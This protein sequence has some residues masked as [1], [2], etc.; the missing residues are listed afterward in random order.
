[1][2]PPTVAAR[3]KP[4]IG[5]NETNKATAAGKIVRQNTSRRYARPIR[6]RDSTHANK[7]RT[8][9]FAHRPVKPFC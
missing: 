4:H 6:T 3:G 2:A 7:K 9:I 5:R 8:H 1:M